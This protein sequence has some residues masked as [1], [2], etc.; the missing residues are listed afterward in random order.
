[1]KVNSNYVTIQRHPNKA[2]YFITSQN[3]QA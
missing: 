3:S 2:A 1:M